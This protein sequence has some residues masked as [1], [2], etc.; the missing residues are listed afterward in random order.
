M[1][2]FLVG[3]R[4]GFNRETIFGIW[5]VVFFLRIYL[6]VRIR[7]EKIFSEDGNSLVVFCLY[8]KNENVWIEF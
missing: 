7:R 5:D 6:D 4:I 3:E 2:N 1:M 8:K